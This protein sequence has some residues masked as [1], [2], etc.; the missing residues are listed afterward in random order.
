MAANFGEAS[1]TRA[2]QVRVAPGKKRMKTKSSTPRPKKI[3]PDVP[4]NAPEVGSFPTHRTV[5]FEL[6]APD[7]RE[8]YLAGSFDGWSPTSLPLFRM[9]NGVWVK[10]LVLE[11]GVYEYLFIVDGI[12]T[13]DPACSVSVAN[14]FGGRNSQVTV[15]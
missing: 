1:Q 15:S 12:W 13:P 5:H 7:A 3:E 8:V 6:M 9:D 10:E 14:P 11:P 2:I 4:S